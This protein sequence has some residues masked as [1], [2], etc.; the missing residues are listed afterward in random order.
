MIPG[1]GGGRRTLGGYPLW[2]DTWVRSGWRVQERPG[3]PAR[4]LDAGN[5]IVREGTPAECVEAA[6]SLAPP[7]PRGPSVVLL[8][9]LARG[10]SVMGRM[11]AA[12]SAA[13]WNV[14]NVG[15]PTLRASFDGH[16]ETVS[17]VAKAMADAGDGEVSLVGHSL[18]GLVARAAAAR[19]G[20][21]GWR[22]GR[23]V[24]VGSP[25]RGAALA[26]VLD[27]LGPLRFL[28][29]DC[30]LACTPERASAVPVPPCR[31]I[32]VVAGGNGGRGYNPALRGDNDGVVSVSET[33]LP[34]GETSFLLVPALHTPLARH[35]ATLAAAARFLETGRL[36]A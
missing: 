30:G 10:R 14:A 29:G 11:E 4:L 31:G 21:D 25:A 17:R 33:R 6:V 15:Y 5:R 36:A 2:A 26:A 24:L 22:A 28:A 32:A 9:G 34:V 27:E 19:A 8:H 13:G 35:P 16:A 20:R 12:L 23:I 18:G 3:A 1:S 7:P